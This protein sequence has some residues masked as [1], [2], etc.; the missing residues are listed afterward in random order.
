MVFQEYDRGGFRFF[1]DN[2]NGFKSIRQPTSSM[3]IFSR[4]GH[5]LYRWVSARETYTMD[6]NADRIYSNYPLKSMMD[7]PRNG[8]FPWVIL[9][10][11]SRFC[12]L[13]HTAIS[14]ERTTF[15]YQNSASPEISSGTSRTEQRTIRHLYRIVAVKD[16]NATTFWLSASP[17]SIKNLTVNFLNEA[18][19]HIRLWGN[20]DVWRI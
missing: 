2:V 14:M 17:D 4:W 3:H 12:Y 9:G 16:Y 1:N 5:N 13:R 8:D 6:W 19:F 15:Q 7:S 11:G 10:A 18:V 20:G